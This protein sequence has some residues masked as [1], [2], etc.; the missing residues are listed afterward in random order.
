MLAVYL[1]AHGDSAE[2]AIRRIRAVEKVAIETSRQIQF[3]EEFAQR[4]GGRQLN[5]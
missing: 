4:S 5:V 2:A 3:L 1:I